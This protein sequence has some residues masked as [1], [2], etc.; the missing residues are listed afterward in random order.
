[1]QKSSL[2][3]EILQQRQAL[4]E[5]EWRT[6]SNLICDR[7]K[8]L[9]LF[10]QSQTI[11]AYFSFR[12]EVELEFLFKLKKKWAFPRCVGKNL[13][14][15]LWQPGEPLVDDKYG[16]KTPLKTAPIV[17]ISSADLILVPVVACDR[18]K[19]RLGYG[20]G[21]Y[22]RLM[23]SSCNL[24]INHIGIAFSFSCVDQIPTDSWDIK[25]DFVCTE[26]ELF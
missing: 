2:R 16:I 24:N 14:W 13:V 11:F 17:S 1:M 4:S 5:T 23:A 25:L 15:H 26:T 19:Y 18:R 22:D 10:T 8:T 7:L 9:P 21:F 3:K 20:G 6:K 12:Q